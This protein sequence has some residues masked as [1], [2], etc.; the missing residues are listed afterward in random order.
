MQQ[1]NKS[2]ADVRTHLFAALDG[3][4]DGSMAIDKAMAIRDIGQTLINSAKVEVDF[5]RVT[6]GQASGFIESATKPPALPNGI[7][8]VTRH[9]M[10]G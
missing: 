7:K 2:L 1:N 8:G 9:L 3:L 4:K 10:N 6:D 5:L